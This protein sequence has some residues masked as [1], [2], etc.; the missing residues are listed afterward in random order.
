MF[1]LVRTIGSTEDLSRASPLLNTM[2]DLF[3]WRR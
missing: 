2:A 1:D 3:G